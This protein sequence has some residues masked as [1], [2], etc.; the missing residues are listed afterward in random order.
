MKFKLSEKQKR[1][2]QKTSLI[3]S[4]LSLIAS[5]FVS[6]PYLYAVCLSIALNILA[7]I[8]SWFIIYVPDTVAEFVDFICNDE[9]VLFQA[10]TTNDQL[11]NLRIVENEVNRKINLL[12]NAPYGV[13]ML[14]RIEEEEPAHTS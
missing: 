12:S 6:F 2:I 1:V 14:P 11:E 8:I 9:Q 4:C 5:T 3:S 7:F 10:E 13:D